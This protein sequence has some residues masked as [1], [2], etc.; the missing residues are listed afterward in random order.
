MDLLNADVEVAH[1]RDQPVDLCSAQSD[2]PLGHQ[3]VT[4][5]AQ[6]VRLCQRVQPLG[7]QRCSSLLHAEELRLQLCE[8]HL[9]LFGLARTIRERQLDFHD[10]GADLLDTLPNRILLVFVVRDLDQI[11]L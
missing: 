7:L 11:A 8:L 3:R 10:A 6:P 4:L 1:V 5:G 2:Q 9:E